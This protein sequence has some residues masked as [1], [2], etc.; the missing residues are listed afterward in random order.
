MAANNNKDDRSEAFV[1]SSVATTCAVGT[2]DAS[3]YWGV[4]PRLM[5]VARAK[6]REDL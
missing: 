2:L 6:Y 3:N 1:A 5:F 4:L